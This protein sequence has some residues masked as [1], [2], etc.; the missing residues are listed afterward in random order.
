MNNA[1]APLVSIII[2]TYNREHILKDAINSALKQTYSNKQIIVVDDG[3]IDGTRD[4][5]NQFKGIKYIYQENGG[6]GKA[7][8]TGLQHA[9]G[10]YIAS[11]DSDDVWNPDFLEQCIEML[12]THQLSFV[13]ANWTQYSSDQRVFDFLKHT[14]LMDKYIDPSGKKWTVLDNAL[15]REI[16]LNLCPSPSSSFVLRQESMYGAWHEQLNIADDWCLLLDMVL[17]KGANAAFTTEKLWSKRTDGKNI[18]DGRNIIELKEYLDINDLRA[19]LERYREHLNE[20]E[21]A[22]FNERI[23]RN[24][25]ELYL[26][27]LFMLKLTANDHRML[28]NALSSNPLQLINVIIDLTYRCLRKIIRTL[29]NK[30]ASPACY[31]EKPTRSEVLH[32]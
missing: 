21:I 15:S 26:I 25:Y 12:E 4:V 14:K 11:L 5:V 8:N 29:I 20:A 2:P 7:R 32:P 18:C 30:V 3:S 19:I 31:N 16:Y 10:V 17:L 24:M 13:F 9:Q 28:K 22:T 27:K 6:Q 23:T 1:T